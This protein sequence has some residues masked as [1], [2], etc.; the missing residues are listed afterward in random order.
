MAELAQNVGF[1]TSNSE[2]SGGVFSFL[3]PI[4]DPA[5]NLTYAATFPQAVSQLSQLFFEAAGA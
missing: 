2:V 3:M 1:N 4:T 5:K